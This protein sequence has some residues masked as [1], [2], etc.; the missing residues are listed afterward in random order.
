MAGDVPTHRDTIGRRAVCPA[1]EG[2][3]TETGQELPVPLFNRLPRGL[4]R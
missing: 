4:P 2:I 1:N 3:E